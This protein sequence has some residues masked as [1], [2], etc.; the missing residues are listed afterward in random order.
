MI[1]N[2]FFKAQHVVDYPHGVYRARVISIT[3]SVASI[4]SFMRVKK[5]V[6]V[7]LRAV[8]G[9]GRDEIKLG[10]EVD[11]R[12]AGGDEAVLVIFIA[13]RA[14]KALYRTAD[15]SAKKV[16]VELPGMLRIPHGCIGWGVNHGCNDTTAIGALTRYDVCSAGNI[17]RISNIGVC[18]LYTSPSPRDR[19]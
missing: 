8:E 1:V 15:I 4:L 13:L 6:D 19:G 3:M 10:H 7:T 17:I 14:G 12:L 11:G 16:I 18:L 9:D 2:A 5:V